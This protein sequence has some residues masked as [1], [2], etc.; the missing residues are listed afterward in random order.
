MNALRMFFFVILALTFL[1]FLIFIT[2]RKTK[3]SQLSI[4][5]RIFT[6]YTHL[7][8]A[9]MSFNVSIPGS[10]TNMFAFA[11]SFSSPNETFFSFDCFVE[12]YE[13]KLMAPSNKMLK[14]VLHVFLPVILIAAIFIIFVI[15][16]GFVAFILKRNNLS[17]S[18]TLEM[19]NMKR[20][21]VVSMI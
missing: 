2:L 21:V 4:L 7:I 17:T 18:S 3:E 1:L 15:I 16:K 10:F 5:L 14:L 12:T 19:Y 6:N 20:T 9:S 13:L 11:G 8:S